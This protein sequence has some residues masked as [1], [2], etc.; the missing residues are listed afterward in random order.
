MLNFPHYSSVVWVMRIYSLEGS[1]KSPDAEYLCGK[2]TI[3]MERKGLHHCLAKQLLL[4]PAYWRLAFYAIILTV[5]IH[6]H[7]FTY[8]LQAVWHGN[9]EH[10]PDIATHFFFFCPIFNNFRQCLSASGITDAHLNDIKADIW[11]HGDM[12]RNTSEQLS[13]FWQAP[14]QKIIINMYWDFHYQWGENGS[15]V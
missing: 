5:V 13:R 11:S 12:M 7:I 10:L 4:L 3:N 8:I 15:C 14:G 9:P 6:M 1:M 2:L